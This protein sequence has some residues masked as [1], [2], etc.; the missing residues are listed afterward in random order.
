M[1][2]EEASRQCEKSIAGKA[3]RLNLLLAISGAKGPGRMRA[4]DGT[5]SPDKTAAAIRQMGKRS[6]ASRVAER[7]G[8]QAP[9]AGERYCSLANSEVKTWFSGN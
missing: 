7:H 6:E 3:H 5:Q 8:F 9:E 2:H 4:K 1:G